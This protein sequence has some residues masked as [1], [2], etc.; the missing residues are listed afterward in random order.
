M[1]QIKGTGYVLT[2][3]DVEKSVEYYSITVVKTINHTSYTERGMI[4]SFQLFILIVVYKYYYLL[5]KTY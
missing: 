3:H 4:L 5:S 1:P 2:I